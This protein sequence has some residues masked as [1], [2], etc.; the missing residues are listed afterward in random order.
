MTDDL[1]ESYEASA[2]FSLKEGEPYTVTLLID[3][4]AV[5]SASVVGNDNLLRVV[6]SRGA[7]E[8]TIRLRWTEAGL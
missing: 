8:G 1:N 7:A 4:I 6:L 3:G 5:W 2:Y